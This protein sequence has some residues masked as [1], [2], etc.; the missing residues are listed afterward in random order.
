VKCFVKRYCPYKG[1]ILMQNEINIIVAKYKNKI[2]FE[3]S[4]TFTKKYLD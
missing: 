4:L 2:H 3:G 1:D